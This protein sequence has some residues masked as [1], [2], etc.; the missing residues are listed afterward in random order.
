MTGHAP[1]F[2][3]RPVRIVVLLATTLLIAGC[4]VLPGT[5]EPAPTD[6]IPSVSPSAISEGLLDSPLGFTP[7][8]RAAVRVRNDSCDELATGSGFVLD[9]HTIITNQHV[10]EDYGTLEVTTSDGRDVEVASVT[11]TTLADVAII[12]TVD[13]LDWSAVLAGDDPGIGDDI[14][15]IGYPLGLELR[16]TTGMVVSREAD[17]LDNADHVFI[18]TA[19]SEPGSSGSAAYNAAGEVFGVLYAGEDETKRSIIIPVSILRQILVDPNPVALVAIA[20]D[21]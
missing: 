3:R 19:L 2:R 18:T 10:V 7:G 13:A 14:T 16:S 17:S 12:T 20:C 15:V 1:R 6:W 9:D 4:G 5:P 8:E 21:F 11:T